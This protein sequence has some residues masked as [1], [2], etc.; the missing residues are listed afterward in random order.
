M[1]YALRFEK[2]SNNE[3]FEFKRIL[4]QKGVSEEEIKVRMMIQ[5]F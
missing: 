3:M 2:Y 4:K 5:A 1:L